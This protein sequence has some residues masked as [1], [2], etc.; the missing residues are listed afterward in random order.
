MENLLSVAAHTEVKMFE[1]KLSQG[2]KPEKGGMLTGIKVTEEIANIRGL[3]VGED[4]ISPNRHE[5]L[6]SNSDLLDMIERVRRVTQ[7]P[8]GFK[9]VISSSVRLDDFF[10]LINQRSLEFAPDFITVDSSDGGTSLN[11][12]HR[13]MIWDYLSKIVCQC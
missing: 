1:I 9:A 11:R 5:E 7:R 13:W 10:A 8:V 4:S 2:A 3:A 6:N 12:C